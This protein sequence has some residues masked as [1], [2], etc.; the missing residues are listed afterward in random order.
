VFRTASLFEA[1]GRGM[2]LRLLSNGG[3]FSSDTAPGMNSLNANALHMKRERTKF[4]PFNP[5]KDVRRSAFFDGFI[6][7]K[8]PEQ[9]RA[10]GNMHCR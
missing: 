4:M 8:N 7:L 5:H 10:S 6:T 3:V 9:N 2:K 1:N